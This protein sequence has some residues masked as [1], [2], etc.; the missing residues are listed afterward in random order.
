[1]VPSFHITYLPQRVAKAFLVKLRRLGNH[2]LSTH[3]P[4]FPW[5]KMKT[6]FKNTRVRLVNYLLRGFFKVNSFVF[7]GA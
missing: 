1:M 2:N 7:S 6:A 3:I 4:G 5:L